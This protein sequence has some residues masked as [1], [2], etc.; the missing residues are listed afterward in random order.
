MVGSG[1]KGIQIVNS[2]VFKKEAQ[3]LEKL[4]T[5]HQLL[6]QIKKRGAAANSDHYFF[7]EKGVKC[8][9]IYTLGNYKEYHNVNDIPKNLP[10]TEYEDLF[11][12]LILFTESL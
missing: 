5:E 2:T 11:R 10:L 6:P 9:F 3:I 4:N 7:Y 12:L 1:D 8:F